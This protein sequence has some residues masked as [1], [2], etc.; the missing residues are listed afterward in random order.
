MG[1]EVALTA[2]LASLARTIA[3]A[4]E[5]GNIALD[6]YDIVQDT[7]A[8]VINILSRHICTWYYTNLSRLY[9]KTP[10]CR[11]DRENR[12]SLCL[13]LHVPSAAQL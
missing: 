4:G 5:V 7:K 12:K 8:A 9:R 10:L 6:V 13:S 2:G 3:I 11:R 1:E